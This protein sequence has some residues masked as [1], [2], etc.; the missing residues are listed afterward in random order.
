MALDKAWSLS[1]PKSLA[2]IKDRNALPTSQGC[3]ESKYNSDNVHIIP[4]AHIYSLNRYLWRTYHVPGQG[5]G[6]KK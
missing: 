1:E 2:Y 6:I 3:Y 4:Y 5:G